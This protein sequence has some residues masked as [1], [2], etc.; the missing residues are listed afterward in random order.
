MSRRPLRIA[1]PAWSNEYALVLK[2]TAICFTIG[3]ME[4]LNRT[5]YVVIATDDALLPYI[6]AGIIF[7][8]L[9]Y[10]GS[11]GLSMVYEKV[12]IPGLIKEKA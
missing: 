6:T 3:V 2:E 12:M 8:A 11:Q 7:V 9:T 5:R 10:V 1:I 4:I